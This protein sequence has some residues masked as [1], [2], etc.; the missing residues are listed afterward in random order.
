MT[1]MTG[2]NTDEA[3]YRNPGLGGVAAIIDQD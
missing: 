3:C 1:A 2:I